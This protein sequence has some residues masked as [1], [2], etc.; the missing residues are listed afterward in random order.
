MSAKPL[1]AAEVPRAKKQG[2]ESQNADL[3]RLLRLE[4]LTLEIG[5][6]LIPLVD[7]NREDSC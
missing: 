1:R 4:E 5:F 7:E 6:Q 2:A 3:A